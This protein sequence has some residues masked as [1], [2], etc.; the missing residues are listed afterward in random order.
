MNSARSHSASLIR[1]PGQAAVADKR[2]PRPAPK[3]HTHQGGPPRRHPVRRGR[4]ANPRP[5]PA[6][7]AAIS[8]PPPGPGH[9]DH[10]GEDVAPAGGPWSWLPRA[11][12]R[13]AP[14][15]NGAARVSLIGPSRPLRR[16]TQSH[17]G[18]RRSVTGRGSSSADA[19]GG[20]HWRVIAG[21]G[22]R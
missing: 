2:R 12:A 7:A 10:A 1:C 5:H 6:V 11:E 13:H 14:S 15:L 19:R 16:S 21:D 20:G 17:H 3:T 8:T 22:P 9:G 18:P 4:Q